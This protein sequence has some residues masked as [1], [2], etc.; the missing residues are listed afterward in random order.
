VTVAGG[1]VTLRSDDFPDSGRA[2]VLFDWDWSQAP[3]ALREVE[4]HDHGH[5]D[6]WGDLVVVARRRKS[7]LPGLLGRDE[8]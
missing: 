2:A 7:L 1:V 3:R 5:G 8:S 4:H 6:G